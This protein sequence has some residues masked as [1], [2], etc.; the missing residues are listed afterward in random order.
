M[1]GTNSI[2]YQRPKIFSVLLNIIAVE[3]LKKQKKN[4]K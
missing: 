1:F 4:K 3:K 2:C